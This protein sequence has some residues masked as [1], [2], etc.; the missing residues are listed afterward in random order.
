LPGF[1]IALAEADA[2]LE[3]NRAQFDEKKLDLMSAQAANLLTPKDGRLTAVQVREGDLVSAGQTLAHVVPTTNDSRQLVH[4]WV[5]S[6]AI[7]FVEKGTSVRLMFDAF[8]YQSFG[9]S[10]GKVIEVASAPILPAEVPMPIPKEEQ[11]YRVVVA[12]DDD[13]LRAYGRDWALSPGMRLTADLV[14]MEK[15]LLDWLLEPL[16]AAKRIADV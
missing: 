3:Q 6:R 15:T 9:I 13:V 5:P 10:K 11:M 14:L 2:N 8:P 12:L 1:E 7:G 4:L 16:T